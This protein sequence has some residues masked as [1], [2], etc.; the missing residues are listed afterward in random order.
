MLWQ[1]C[2]PTCGPEPLHSPTESKDT[3]QTFLWL[4]LNSL[5]CFCRRFENIYVGWGLK[6]TGQGYSPCVPPPPQQEYP[7]GP[8]VTEMVDPSVEEEEEMRMAL[9]EQQEVQQESEEEEEDEED[10]N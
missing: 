9:E 8:E 10:D 2:D 5:S 6:Y 3:A 1:C 7:S 4:R